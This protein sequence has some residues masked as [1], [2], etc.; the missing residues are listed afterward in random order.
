MKKILI[1]IL[2]V[3]L[4]IFGYNQYK[5]Y[6]RFHPEQVNYTTTQTIDLNYHNQDVVYNYYE[7]IEELNHYIL[8]QW[9]ANAIDVRN[10]EI[11]DEAHQ[12][13]NKQYAKKMAKV[14]FYEAKLAQSSTYKSNGLDNE[15][16]KLIEENNIS[17]EEIQAKEKQLVFKQMMLDMF[18]QNNLFFGQKSA[19]VYEIQKLLVKKGFQIPVDGVYKNATSDAILQ[20]ELKNGLFADGKLDKMTLNT[21][22]N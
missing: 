10:P 22:L 4:L 15:K 18:P 21:L 20:F 6:K 7:A 1:A 13:A 3:I 14:K 8:S 5:D 19:F 12:Y 11:D 16:I 9:T 2:V 17:I